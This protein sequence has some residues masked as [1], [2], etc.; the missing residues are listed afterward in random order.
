M[1]GLLGAGLLI[2]YFRK[3]SN[4]GICNPEP[5]IIEYKPTIEITQIDLEPVIECLKTHVSEKNK[6]FQIELVKENTKALV[7]VQVFQLLGV[8]TIFVVIGYFGYKYYKNYKE[9]E[10]NMFF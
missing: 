5:N 6:E 7:Q 1:I 10:K 2:L 9:K 3:S 8:T 4:P